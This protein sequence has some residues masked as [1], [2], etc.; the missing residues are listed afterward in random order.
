MG[1]AARAVEARSSLNLSPRDTAE[2]DDRYSLVHPSRGV[3]DVGQHPEIT[4]ATS[5]AIPCS[6]PRASGDRPR[7]TWRRQGESAARRGARLG[8]S[9]ARAREEAASARLAANGPELEPEAGSQATRFPSTIS[10][11]LTPHEGRCY[12]GD[13]TVLPCKVSTFCK[14]LEFSVRGVGRGVSFPPVFPRT[15]TFLRKRKAVRAVHTYAFSILI[16]FLHLQAGKC[17]LPSKCTIGSSW[18]IF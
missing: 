4:H 10:R 9:R 14:L 5:P 7:E 15:G 16:I 2:P 11:T 8:Q 13:L 17:I 18:E 12:S 6:E 1:R 3:G